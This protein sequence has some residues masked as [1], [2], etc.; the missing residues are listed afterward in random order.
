MGPTWGPSGSCRP[1]MGPVLAPRTLLSGTIHQNLGDTVLRLWTHPLR[2][3]ISP[4]PDPMQP[5]WIVY[6]KPEIVHGIVH[7][8]SHLAAMSWA[9]FFGAFLIKWCVEIK[10]IEL[11]IGLVTDGHI[12]SVKNYE[13]YLQVRLK[14]YLWSLRSIPNETTF[15]KY[16][17]TQWISKLPGRITWKTSRICWY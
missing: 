10:E 5:L 14:S 4:G 15:T 13:K 6:S 2:R 17:H 7:V 16:C 1:Q 8:K 12:D 11:D 3:E 9:A